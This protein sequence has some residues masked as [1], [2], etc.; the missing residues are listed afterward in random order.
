MTLHAGTAFG[1]GSLVHMSPRKPNLIFSTLVQAPDDF[2]GLVAYGI[3]K[4]RKIDFIQ[5]YVSENSADIKQDVLDNFHAA[6]LS[7]VPGYRIEASEIIQKFLQEYSDQD[8]ESF[9]S[10]LESEYQARSTNLGDEYRNKL[11]RMKPS[12]L[13]NVVQSAVGSFVFTIAIGVVVIII[14]G[15]RVG[16]GGILEEFVR[17]LAP[18]QMPPS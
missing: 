16:V 8:V 1:T 14:L 10:T 6:C 12:A 9:K 2:I 3:Y 4:R 15:L 7:N 11:E 18:L 5:T 13:A 17:M